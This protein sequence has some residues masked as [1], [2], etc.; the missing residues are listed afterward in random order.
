MRV[1]GPLCGRME[2]MV[3]RKIKERRRILRTNFTYFANVAREAPTHLLG[4]RN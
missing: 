2:M 4:G 1:L 3:Y